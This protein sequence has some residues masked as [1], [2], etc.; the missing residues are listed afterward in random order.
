MK[1][2]ISLLF[3]L[4][5][6][7]SVFG[8][9]VKEKAEYEKEFDT[10]QSIKIA[11]LWVGENFKSGKDVISTYDEEL[12]TLIGNG[13]YTEKGVLIDLQ[14]HFKFK[15]T[16]KENKVKI[17]FS[18]LAAGTKKVPISKNTSGLDKFYAKLDKLAESLFEYYEDF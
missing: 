14:Y 6:T 3:V 11:K 9:E 7:T 8:V 1:K 15:I 16:V 17:V 2:L 13:F 10:P 4:L 18:D 12:N 5:F